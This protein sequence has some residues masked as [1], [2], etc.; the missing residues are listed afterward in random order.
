MQIPCK[1]INVSSL[2]AETDNVW[3]RIL[4]STYIS[5][6]TDPLCSTVSVW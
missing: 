6:K 4:S 1:T 5:S 3:C 2:L